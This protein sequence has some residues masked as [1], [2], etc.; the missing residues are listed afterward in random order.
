MKA[1]IAPI[2]AVYACV[3]WL[4]YVAFTAVTLTDPTNIRQVLV[5]AIATPI[6]LIIIWL[7]IRFVDGNVSH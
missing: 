5:W 2:L 4:G 6:I 3:Q 1:A 7:C